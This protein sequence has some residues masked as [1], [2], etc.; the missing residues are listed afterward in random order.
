M[1]NK[2]SP[3][4]IPGLQAIDNSTIS[5]ER[6]NN[7]PFIV[8]S[9]KMKLAMMLAQGIPLRFKY[10]FVYAIHGIIY[11]NL[12]SFID[13]YPA[14]QHNANWF[15]FYLRENGMLEVCG[16]EGYVRSIFQGLTNE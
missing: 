15:I 2:K 7:N 3:A 6:K 4:A 9:E 11:A 14:Q 16:G 1:I 12:E 5:H 8:N 13:N 10:P